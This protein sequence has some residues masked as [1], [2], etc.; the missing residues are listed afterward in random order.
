MKKTN[1]TGT[2][3]FFIEFLI[4][5]FFFLIVSTVCLKI[6]VHAH[7]ITKQAEALSR[8][9][10]LAS[11][12]AEVLEE[13]TERDFSSPESDE[14][15]TEQ[16]ILSLK[17]IWPEGTVSPEVFLL[18]CNKNFE[19]C[20]PEQ[21]AYQI[22]VTLE[23]VPFFSNPSGSYSED[24][25]KFSY[26]EFSHDRKADIRITSSKSETIYN[27]SVFFHIPLTYEEVLP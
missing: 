18:T 10:A 26:P 1:R 3:L 5:L 17:E 22:S 15:I 20:E 9:Q 19:P 4:V 21:A 8:G 13:R 25:E 6:F 23:S 27:L 7:Q 12:M 16:M 2:R 14:Y 24:S 11:S